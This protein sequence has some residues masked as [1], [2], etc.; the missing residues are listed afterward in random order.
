VQVV[1]GS[2][3]TLQAIRSLFDYVYACVS[4]SVSPV[5][6]RRLCTRC[7]AIWP[8]AS[9]PSATQRRASASQLPLQQLLAMHAAPAV[10]LLL[11]L[12]TR[13]QLPTC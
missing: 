4:V 9:Q 5:Q 2:K 1:R 3:F 10:R 13:C 7:R 6:M 8:P 12:A 11:A